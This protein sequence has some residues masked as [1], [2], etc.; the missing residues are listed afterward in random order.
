MKH[1]FIK[2]LTP[3]DWKHLLK[4]E[5]S[6]KKNS[7]LRHYIPIEALGKQRTSKNSLIKKF[8]SS[9]NLTVLSDTKIYSNSFHTQTSL[10]DTIF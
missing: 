9:F 3:N 6:H 8:T 10:K 7:L 1:K 4:T 2:D 5:T